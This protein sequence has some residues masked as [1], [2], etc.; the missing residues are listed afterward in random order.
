MF[1][2]FGNPLCKV[3]RVPHI[4]NCLSNR[5]SHSWRWFLSPRK[6]GNGLFLQ[7]T[8]R[9]KLVSLR[10]KAP[11]AI[12]S[13]VLFSQEGGF[14]G[15]SECWLGEKHGPLM[16]PLWDWKW[17]R[18]PR[19][20]REEEDEGVPKNGSFKVSWNQTSTKNHTLYTPAL[21]DCINKSCISTSY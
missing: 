13:F 14:A 21:T 16:Q 10:A 6:T 9:T 4:S 15:K 2:Q 11:P 7:P 18:L 12:S 17:E 19:G 20:R 1:L 5:Q 3:Q 8:K